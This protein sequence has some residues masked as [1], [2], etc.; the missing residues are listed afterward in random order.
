MANEEDECDSSRLL[1]VASP[2]DVTSFLYAQ[3]A[4]ITSANT[5]MSDDDDDGDPH[6]MSHPLLARSTQVSPPTK[7]PSHPS[8]SRSCFAAISSS[9]SSSSSQK[10]NSSDDLTELKWLTTFKFKDHLIDNPLQEKTCESSEP[11]PAHEDRIGKLIHQLKTDDPEQL[12]TDQSSFGPAIFLALYSKRD[13]RQ[14][15]WSLSIKQ[16]YDFIQTRMKTL[17]QR[18]AW[19]HSI[20]QTLLVTPCFVK[21][22]GD[23]LKSRSIWTID[24]YYRPSL[25]RAY[26]SN[27]LLSSP[28]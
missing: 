4:K 28:K 2:S 12:G 15:P 11:S 23:V 3:A 8:L 13:D 20:R 25:I 6:F 18:C 10:A 9:S 14:N 17:T 21:T 27:A 19:K 16:I 5:S 7:I 24:T 1:T 22:K 26:T